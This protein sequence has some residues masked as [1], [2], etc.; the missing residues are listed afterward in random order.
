MG[1]WWSQMGSGGAGGAAW[2]D[3]G[4]KTLSSGVL[5]ASDGPGLYVVAA[6]AGVADDLTQITG[7]TARQG[8]RIQADSGDTITVKD[9]A[10]L[11]LAGIDFP[12]DDV[13]DLM[14]LMCVSAGV[15][16]EVLRSDND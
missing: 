7:L 3:R 6:E 9:G 11:N 12:L 5:D 14:E 4:T 8:V 2:E 1:L 13:N 16:T 10:N 15:A